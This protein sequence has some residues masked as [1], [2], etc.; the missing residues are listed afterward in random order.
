MNENNVLEAAPAKPKEKKAPRKSRRGSGSIFRPAGTQNW[1]IQFFLN[2]KRRRESTGTD[3][4]RAAQ[5]KLAVR[6]AQVVK[7][8][9]IEAKPKRIL[10]SEL[11]DSL[12][13]EYIR[14]GRKSIRALR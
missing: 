13:K 3:D 11:L 5:Q 9:A 1:S 2:G 10:V 14:Q 7:G 6:L 4:F 12:E 8:E